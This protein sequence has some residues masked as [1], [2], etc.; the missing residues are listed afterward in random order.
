MSPPPGRLTARLGV[1]RPALLAAALLAASAP[2]HAQD[3][4][5][6]DDPAPDDPA[7]DADPQAA[8]PPLEA[9]SCQPTGAY[10][11]LGRMDD[12][13]SA[14][15]AK[16]REGFQAAAREIVERLPCLVDVLTPEQAA[17]VHRFMGLYA[18][19]EQRDSDG[20]KRSFGAARVL[21]PDHELSEA[22]SNPSLPH[23]AAYVGVLAEPGPRSPLLN[24]ARVFVDGT[25]ATDRPEVWPAVV[26]LSDGA[27]GAMGTAY[28]APDEPL[29]AW[30][31]TREAERVITE[32]EARTRVQ[33][34]LPAV[35]TMIGGVVLTGVGAGFALA[36]VAGLD[37]DCPDGRCMDR[38]TRQA[39]NTTGWTLMVLGVAGVGGGMTWL[40]VNA[41]RNGAGVRVAGRF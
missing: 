23:Y 37:E 29:P 11:L 34:S 14:Y 2:A 4:P 30:I 7:A 35:G 28:L 39:L 21:D 27:D 36:S 40:G 15:V 1:V 38:D 3:A 22:M 9:G 26:Q 25:E 18:L 24:D 33:R 19:L 20:M 17:A 12:A 16:D 13:T 10:R 5:A 32:S 6:P 41:G 8:A 31:P